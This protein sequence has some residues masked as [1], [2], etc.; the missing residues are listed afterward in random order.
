MSSVP[1]KSKALA[2][3][4]TE[5]HC[6]LMILAGTA[7]VIPTDFTVSG[8]ELT[9]RLAEELELFQKRLGRSRWELAG[10]SRQSCTE[11]AEVGAG[12]PQSNVNVNFCIS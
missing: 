6:C 10:C 7:Q 8:K 2:L 12:H 1:L 5:C 3:H 11:V 9:Q 4:S